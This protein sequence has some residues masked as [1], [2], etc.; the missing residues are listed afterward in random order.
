MKKIIKRDGRI[1]DF[2]RTKIEQA[3]LK[4]F[5]AVDGEITD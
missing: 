3:I 2:D 4:A 5:A 1:V